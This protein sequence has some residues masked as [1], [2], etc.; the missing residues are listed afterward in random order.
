MACRERRRIAF[1]EMGARADALEQ[2]NSY[3]A[4]LLDNKNQQKQLLAL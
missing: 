2:D 4:G 3:L 1:G